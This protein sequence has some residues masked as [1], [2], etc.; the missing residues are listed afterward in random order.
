MSDMNVHKTGKSLNLVLP[1][2]VMEPINLLAT[3]ECIPVG[4]IPTT[5]VAAT[6]CQ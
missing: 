3:Q 4:N 1:L 2:N 5:V 6:R